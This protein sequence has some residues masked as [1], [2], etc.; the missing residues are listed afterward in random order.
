MHRAHPPW[1]AFVSQRRRGAHPSKFFLATCIFVASRPQESAALYDRK[2][3]FTRLGA[4][5]E[6]AADAPHSP[7]LSVLVSA[8][9]IT[10]FWHHA[11]T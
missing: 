9:F 6:F 8:P 11:L 4:T 1:L 10:D 5:S 3:E 7:L 2:D